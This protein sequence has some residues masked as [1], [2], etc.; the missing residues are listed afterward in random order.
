VDGNYV[1]AESSSGVIYSA[2]P[3]EHTR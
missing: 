2:R 3:A 1:L